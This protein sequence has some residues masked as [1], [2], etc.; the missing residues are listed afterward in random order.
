MVQ[1]V[2]IMIRMGTIMGLMAII[3]ET[4][5]GLDMARARI[6]GMDLTTDQA[7]E[8]VK[9]HMDNSKAQA[10]KAQQV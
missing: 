9:I 6:M 7:M 1:A 10:A 3:M 5:M 2:T 8:I 4:L